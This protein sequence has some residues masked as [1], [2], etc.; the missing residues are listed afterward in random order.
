MFRPTRHS[1]RISRWCR[2]LAAQEGGVAVTVALIAPVLIGMAAL[3]LDLGRAWSTQTEL[4]NA[5]DAAA[6]AGASQL[7]NEFGAMDRA[8]DAAVDELVRNFQTFAAD[9]FGPVAEID[10]D[11]IRFFIAPGGAEAM[12]DDEANYIEV[13]VQPRSLAFFL[14]P[15]VGGMTEVTAGARAMAGMGSA[16][17]KVPPMFI[18]MPSDGNLA[19]GR[20]V[21]M[22]GKSQGGGGGSWAPGNFGI[23]GLDTGQGASLSANLI[24]DAMG[25]ENPL[26]QCFGRDDAQETKPGETTA[27]RDGLNMRFDI[28]PNN[29]NVPSGEPQVRENPQ[30]RP[31]VNPVKG[32]VKQ[33]NSCRITNNGWQRP[34][35]HY[36]GPGEHEDIS[37]DPIEAMGF[38]RDS[39]AYPDENGNPGSCAATGNDGRFGDGQWDFLA[40]M[41]VNHPTYVNS[42]MTI[43]QWPSDLPGN[44]S[45]HPTRFEVFK[46]EI[47]NQ[48]NPEMANAP[49]CYNGPMPS[50][51][52][53]ITDRRVMTVAVVDCTGLSGQA[54]V[55][56]TDWY[57]I[58]LTEPMG[59]ETHPEFDDPNSLYAEIIGPADDPGLKAE[60]VRH[61]LQL[62]E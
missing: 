53:A 38:P 50:S 26:A 42:D 62:V 4:Q 44:M 27:I 20:G 5:A 59:G 52:D 17:C 41:A 24:R 12:S 49:Q 55:Q 19:P 18:C 30:Y 61:I 46:W 34:D 1:K 2:H 28:Y 16:Y 14:A 22:K 32:L 23:L 11:N 36:R 9:A 29:H 7:D 13:F 33:G 21:W 51:V 57:N 43:S 15:V 37:S 39:C 58:F 35:D 48:P 3:A 10:A 8:R 60:V 47:E 6:L 25:R 40:Y 54:Q 31:S 45:N 56:P